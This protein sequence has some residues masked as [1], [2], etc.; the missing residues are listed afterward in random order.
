MPARRFFVLDVHHAGEDVAIEGSDAHKIRNVLRLRSGDAIEIVD[1]AGT[2]FDAVLDVRDGLYAQLREPRQAPA[3]SYAIDVAQ[4]I[5]KGQKM[6][7]VVEKLSELG[8]RRLIPVE[9]ERTIVHRIAPAKLERWRRLARG[10]AQQSGRTGVLAVQEPLS[11]TAL[12]DVFPDYDAVLVPW[13]VAAP[14]PLR[15]A[16]PAIVAGASRILVVVGPEGGFS[17]GE[18][19]AAHAAGG[20]LVSLGPRILRTETAALACVAILSYL[21]ER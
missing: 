7:F 3:S 1:S 12:R 14:R 16:L 11:L 9:S 10:A 4:G 6:D 20:H 19:E 18:A 13:E 15:D 21:L 5:P 2:V 17:H 8:V